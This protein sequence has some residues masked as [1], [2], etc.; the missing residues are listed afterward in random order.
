M[1]A[2]KTS[3]IPTSGLRAEISDGTV[4]YSGL[5]TNISR[6]GLCIQHISEKLSS[7]RSLISIVIR[8]STVHYR[9]VARPRWEQFQTGRGKTIGVEIARAPE[10]W[11]EFILSFSK[12]KRVAP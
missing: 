9:V 2:R 10:N 5:V 12:A 4:S 3:R 6:L 1:E 11:N 8:N 7:S